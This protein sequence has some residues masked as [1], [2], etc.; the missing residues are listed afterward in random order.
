[1]KINY[2]FHIHTALSPCALDEM[3]PN[4]VVNMSIISELDAI[5]V[6][7]HNSCGNAKA[8]MTVAESTDLIVIPGMEV[9]SREEIHVVCL[10]SDLDK[11]ESMQEFVYSNL[12][13]LKNKPK[14]LGHQRLMDEEDEIVGEEESLLSF[15]TSITF[16]DVVSK[17]WELGGIAVPAHIDRPSYSVI[18]NLGILPPDELLKCLEISQYAEYE[19]FD[20][21][22]SEYLMLQ[23]SDSH[24]LGFIG[25]CRQTLDIPLAVDEK[26][27]AKA[28]ID[29]LRNYR[30]RND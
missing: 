6:A 4:N 16:E 27:S 18:S 1:M 13:M 21:R 22:Y 17:A 9:E 15:A 29:Y 23:S 12:P 24:E 25:I 5:A 20:K 10:F 19:E 30:M 2:D 26:L 14:V 28:I 3:T 8:V 7:D 11:A